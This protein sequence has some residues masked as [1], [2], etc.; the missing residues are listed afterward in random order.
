MAVDPLVV[1]ADDRRDF[2]VVVHAGE[3]PLSNRRVVLHQPSLSQ[4]QGA[5]FLQEAGREP[6]FP[7]V[8]D[9]ARQ[10]HE[11]LL[12]VGQPHPLGDFSRVS[13][14]RCRVTRRVTVSRVK[15]GHERACERKIR[16]LESRVDVRKF[17]GG[18]SLLLVEVQETVQRQSDCQKNSRRPHR[19]G[20]IPIDEPSHNGHIKRK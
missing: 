16:S 2:R 4:G 6:D 19:V 20:A 5:S 17:T 14:N 15:G 12:K 7:D 3:D 13:S 1:V 10:V 18:L 9:K 11:I 8:V